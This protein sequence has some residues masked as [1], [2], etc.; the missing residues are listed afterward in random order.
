MS[1][2]SLEI[3]IAYMRFSVCSIFY[4]LFFSMFTILMCPPA[5][6]V[7]PNIF[8]FILA[9][10]ASTKGAGVLKAD[11]RYILKEESIWWTDMMA[12]RSKTMRE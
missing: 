10:L 8:R 4:I 3:Y 2:S 1:F 11:L 5:W 6:F 12:S 7:I 9:Y